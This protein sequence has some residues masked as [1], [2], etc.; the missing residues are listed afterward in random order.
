MP[1]VSH[2]PPA[3]S[4]GA[5]TGETAPACC[6]KRDGSAWRRTAALWLPSDVGF[7]RTAAALAERHGVPPQAFCPL[8]RRAHQRPGRPSDVRA[9]THTPGAPAIRSAGRPMSC[10]LARLYAIFE[11]SLDVLRPELRIGSKLLQAPSS[12]PAESRDMAQKRPGGP[13]IL[14]PGDDGHQNSLICLS[15]GKA[16]FGAP[17]AR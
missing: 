12:H 11:A 5:G 9:G 15:R 10:H 8:R 3:S 2:D 7:R 14:F 16:S 4:G 1:S 13:Q 17:W 6:L